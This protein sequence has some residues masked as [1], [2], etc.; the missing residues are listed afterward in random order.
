MLA[1]VLLGLV[2]DLAFGGD[3]D[4][5]ARLKGQRAMYWA[6]RLMA[7]KSPARRQTERS[8]PKPL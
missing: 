3:A 5:A 2:E 4:E 1:V 7:S 8:T 6:R